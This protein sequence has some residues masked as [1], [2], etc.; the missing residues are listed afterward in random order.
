MAMD[1]FIE[2]I[3]KAPNGTKVGGLVALV[4]AVTA[5]NGLATGVPR[6]GDPIMDI[7]AK[8]EAADAEQRKLD[9]DLIEKTAIANNLNQF[10]H[11]KELL[12]QRLAEALA[13]LPEDKNLDELLALFQDRA[14]KTGL[15]ITSIEPQGAVSEGFYA[16]IP[17]PMAVNGSFHEIATFFDAIG[18]LRRIVNVSNIAMDTPKDTK[19][20][21]VVNAKFLATTFM[22]VKNPPPAP[23]APKASAR[24]K[25]R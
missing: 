20:R 7:E 24:G 3:A 22:F 16:K 10:R 6:L 2:R 1:Q 18:R 5:L 11:E 13:E 25:K 23:V 21:V 19:G 8:I 15:E 14:A 4:I 9:G 12:E 17:M